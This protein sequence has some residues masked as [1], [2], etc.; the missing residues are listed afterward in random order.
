MAKT[1][2]DSLDKGFYPPYPGSQTHLHRGQLDQYRP[3]IPAFRPNPCNQQSPHRP[4]SALCPTRSFMGDPK[5]PP[6]RSISPRFHVR[7]RRIS[8]SF[9]SPSGVL[10]NF[11]LRYLFTIG[12][13]HSYLALDGRH[14][15]YS[16]STFKLTYSRHSTSPTRPTLSRI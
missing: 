16:V 14:H 8:C 12:P 13:S 7:I 9:S 10:F 1:R 5:A 2:L 15:P 3:G 6:L 4:M 11:P